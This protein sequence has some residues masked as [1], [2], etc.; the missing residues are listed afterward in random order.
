MRT[1]ATI[2]CLLLTVGPS[3][4]AEPTLARLSFW[5]APER[6]D[7][8][9]TAYQ[10]K[11]LPIL[12]GHGMVESAQHSRATVDSVF[13]RLFEFGTPANVIGV[14]EALAANEPWKALLK[15][16]GIA[17]DTV[18]PGGLIRHR[19][20][21]YDAVFGTGKTVP[22]GPGTVV[23]AGPGRGHW[24]RFDVT[25][26]LGYGAIGAIL[27]DRRGFLWVGTLGGV[28]R[29]DGSTFTTFTRD[30]GLP[31]NLIFDIIEDRAGYLWFGTSGGV[32]RFDPRIDSEQAWTTF[33]TDSDSLLAV[34][35][36]AEDRGGNIWMGTRG[37]G[38]RRYDGRSFQVFTTSDGL[39]SN[40][41]STMM[42]DSEGNLWF[43]TAGA[44]GLSRY[45][46]QSWRSFG[47]GDG[48]MS[49]GR[50]GDIIQDRD[51]NIWIA[52]NEP[53]WAG[54][55]S[56]GVYRYDGQIFRLFSEENGL[57]DNRVMSMV[58]DSDGIFW[59]ATVG[60]GVSRYDPT[61]DQGQAWTSFG[62]QDGLSD[63]AVSIYLDREENLWVGTQSGLNRYSRRDWTTYTEADG[64]LGSNLAALHEDGTGHLWIWGGGHTVRFDGQTWT[65]FSAADGLPGGWVVSVYYDRDGSYWF[66]TRAGVA[67]YNPGSPS[68]DNRGQPGPQTATFTHF[69]TED[70]LFAPRVRAIYRDREDHLWFH[71]RAGGSDI[72]GVS[73]FDGQRIEVFTSEDG[74]ARTGG[75]RFF[76]DREGHIWIGSCRFDGEVFTTF[77]TGDGLASNRSMSPLQ[78]QRGHLW[79]AHGGMRVGV[80]RYDGDRFIIYDQ[81]DGLGGDDVRSVVEDRNG[82]LWF[83]IG[84]GGVTRYDGQVFQ[85][86]T[87]RDGLASNHVRDVIE[88][89]RGDIW[90]ATNSGL[91][92]YRQPAPSPPP[93]YIDA[94]VTDRR[95]EGVSDLAVP[96]DLP[97]VAV[98]F[99]GLSFKTRPGAM[100]YR[101]R[102]NPYHDWRTTRQQRVEYQDLPRGDYTFEVEAVDRDL[103]YSESPAVV[104]LTVHVPYERVG[105]WSG[106]IVAILLVGWQTSRVVRR[107]RRLREGNQAL[108]DANKELFQVNVD[109][110][111][112][113]VDLQREQVL[114]R[115]RGQAQGMQSSEDIGPVVEAV[116][117]ELKELG[118]PLIESGIRINVSET[119]VEGW[120]TDEDG[121]AL[122]PFARERSYGPIE[123]ARRRGNDYHH[124][125]IE[126]DELRENIR[127]RAARGNPRWKGVPEDRWP[128]KVEAYF[129]F[130]AGG[131]FDVHSEEPIPE[132]YLMLIKRFGEVFGYAHSRYKELQE[133]EAQNRRLTVEA[134][135]QRLR[136]EV[137]SMDEA[138]DFERILSLLTESLKTVELSFDGCE[139]DV[140][141][142]P[143]EN[144]TMA[145]FEADGFRCT[146][147]RMDPQGAVAAKSYNTP[148]P[149]PGVI[150]RTIER[151][152]AGEPWQGT[153]EGEAIVE[154]PAGAYGR[155]RLT[156]TDRQSFDDDE[157]ATLREFADAVALGYARYLDIREIQL[158]TERKSEFLASMSHELRTPMNAIKGFT[159]FVLR[160]DKSMEE[161]S[162]ENLQKVTQ[163][164]DRLLAMIDDL[165]DLSKIE[166]GRMDVE[167]TTFNVKEL[168][169]SACDTV[170]PLIQEGVELKRNVADDIDEANTD[171]A[172]LQGVVINLL[173]N[174]IKFTDSGSVTVTASRGQGAGSGG[175]D[176]VI[177]VSDTGKGIPAEE[178]PTIFDEYRQAEGSES[179]VQKGTGLGLSITK[180]FAELLG[181]TIGV[182]SEVGMG[183]TF[184]VRVPMEHTT[185]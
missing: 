62:S 97:V 174:A 60:G 105:V 182:E 9:A 123:D 77:T 76:E 175:E 39:A 128:R 53:F 16:L 130:F 150:E 133:K 102:L 156:A 162:R 30:D 140:L 178:L 173:S 49:H 36:L 58:Q 110:E 115:L 74:L 107:D 68:R 164:S 61:A 158:N 56:S 43:G 112:V 26:G 139:I 131:R 92:R 180:K 152:I 141:D 117:R 63:Q 3:W 99:R 118:L 109:L 113:N 90:F 153:S 11:L 31:G 143:V 154:V 46:G 5:L 104:A 48:F 71:Y 172:R 8:F 29:F 52:S 85:T 121:D 183:S 160:R 132:E 157:V 88:G 151:F 41:V 185:S 79:F 106:L 47:P 93:I 12:K 116:D 28:S 94:V 72:G 134:S 87:K 135:V 59:F 2:L 147:F 67:R 89:R 20:A 83:A 176:L 166:A 84:G 13:S 73:R 19:L 42:V 22:A 55:P 27:Q 163:A 179:A 78:D 57:A 40:Y 149:F 45:D 64:L 35:C 169:T 114:E 127:E 54:G 17:Y 101:Y 14:Q 21:V 23:P 184:T 122:E 170:S 34:S 24:D 167:A 44:D 75:G 137:Q 119:Q 155:L 108:S 144:P 50:F 7:E 15:E 159:D 111:S 1:Y 38:V 86:V 37:G 100:V 25:D 91:T 69:S 177:A 33:A 32:C 18:G 136:A 146:T 148:A 51:G 95:Y 125:H 142:E 66:G 124:K 4:S 82:H 80:T 161:R 120:T 96:S 129:V 171:K 6:M 103:V 165:M 145:H 138:S 10:E 70:G 168:I 65:E 126:D 81:K 98:E 181:G